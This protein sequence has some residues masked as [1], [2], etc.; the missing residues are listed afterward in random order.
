MQFS[1]N[2]ILLRALEPEDLDFLYKWE[3]DATLW[4]TSTTVSPY[5]RFD[6]KRYIEASSKDI[7]EQGCL[8][9]IIERVSDKARLGI[10]DLFNYDHFNSRMEI[11]ILIDSQFR[12]KGYALQAVEIARQYAFDFLHLKQIYCHIPAD[13]EVSALLFQKAGFKK[14]AVLPKWIKG[15]NDWTDVYVYQFVL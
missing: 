5:S 13:N 10:L 9:L 12:S 7:F 3:N 6:L 14:T 11:G 15:E 4:H 2:E 8:K 1:N